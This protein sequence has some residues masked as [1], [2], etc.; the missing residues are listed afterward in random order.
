MRPI[1]SSALRDN[2]WILAHA[3]QVACFQLLGSCQVLKEM[4]CRGAYGAEIV[5]L[6]A[7]FAYP[8]AM[9]TEIDPIDRELLARLR[10][11]ESI[12]PRMRAA[13]DGLSACVTWRADDMGAGEVEIVRM[14]RAG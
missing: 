13:V 4:P 9:F 6:V 10:V 14:E 12:T 11:L 3:C 5:A 2:V 7:L 1:A 8:S